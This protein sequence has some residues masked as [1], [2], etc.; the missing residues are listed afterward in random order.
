MLAEPGCTGFRL[1]ANRAGAFFAAFL[2]AGALLHNLPFAPLVA[3]LLRGAV[4]RR[5]AVSAVPGLTAGLGAGALFNRVPG[6][7]DMVAV[8]FPLVKYLAAIPASD[9]L[10]APLLAVG[11][12]IAIPD[13]RTRLAITALFI[14]TI[15]GSANSTILF[16]PF[17]ILAVGRLTVGP[18]PVPVV[19]AVNDF[20]MTGGHHAQQHDHRHDQ[21]KQFLQF[22]VFTSVFYLFKTIMDRMIKETGFTSRAYPPAAAA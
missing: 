5:T 22:H 10:D 14:A 8:D 17:P 4:L 12:R 15:A 21:R 16:T 1:A 18:A 11:R 13:P 9:V 19:V 20:G 2:D 3:A 7:P 6:T